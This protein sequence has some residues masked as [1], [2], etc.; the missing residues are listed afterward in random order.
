[1]MPGSTLCGT[2]I[3]A[4]NALEQSCKNCGNCAVA[5]TLGRSCTILRDQHGSIA[6]VNKMHSKL[7]SKSVK[8]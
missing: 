6:H 3:D 7:C 2:G 8:L 4:F 5:S 1:M